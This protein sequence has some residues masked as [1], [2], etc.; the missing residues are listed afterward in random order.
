M[1]KAILKGS[2]QLCLSNFDNLIKAAGTWTVIL[3]L[4][5]FAFGALGSIGGPIANDTMMGRYVGASLIQTLPMLLLQVVAASSI[6]VAWHR[7]A[8]LGEAPATFHVRFGKS[9]FRYAL[10]YLLFLLCVFAM[11]AVFLL[12]ASLVVML[13]GVGNLESTALTGLG[14]AMILS[15]LFMVPIWARVSLML[16]AAAVDEPM[17][18]VRAYHYGQGMGW[19]M[20]FASICLLIPFV[21]LDLAILWILATIGAGLPQLFVV[22]QFLL[23]KGLE[24]III[25]VLL[26]S[27]ITVAYA[28]ARRR[29]EATAEPIDPAA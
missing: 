23:L 24:Q 13:T 29:H 4:G 1:F 11:S 7:F 14:I 21:L 15:C 20:T 26:L 12:F 6:A 22:I 5:G 16:P 8:L 3:I 25:T 2:V 19:A 9:E 27:V 28:L 10:Y 17:G 18:P